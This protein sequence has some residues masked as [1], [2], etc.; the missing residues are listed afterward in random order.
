MSEEVKDIQTESTAANQTSSYRSIFKAT[1]LFGGVQ[2][3][4][5][6]IQ[7]IRSK[8]IAILLG[9]TGIGIQGL[10]TSATLFVR[11]LSSMGLSQSAVKDVS[12][13][14]LSGEK[15]KAEYILS[16]VNKLVFYTGLFG[17]IIVAIFSP[18]LSKT[19]FGS[20]SY[21]ISFILLSVTLLFDQLYD[22]KR[23]I[24]QGTRQLKRLA[25]VSLLSATIA[26]LCT[27]PL[28]YIWGEKGIVPALIVNSV[29][30]YVII[31][32]LS[33]NSGYK[34]SNVKLKDAITTGGAMLKMGIAM[35]FSGIFSTACAYILRSFIRYSDGTDAVGLY[36]AGFVIINTYVGLVFSAITTDYYPRLAAV[37]NDKEKSR[38]VVN[39]QGEIG[40]IILAPLL[41]VCIL[42]MPLIIVVLYSNDFMVA[43]DFIIYATIGMVFR[44]ISVLGA[45]LF[46]VNGS[47]RIYLLNEFASGLYMLFLNI[48]GYKLGGLAGLGISYAVG[49]FL[50]V[51]QVYFFTHKLYDYSYSVT[52]LR[53]II[54]YSILVLFT[55]V[56]VKL[57]PVPYSWVVG[58]IL[59]IVAFTLAYSDLNK[60]ILLKETILKIL[61]KRNG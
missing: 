9:P 24:L 55:I 31:S 52:Y 20:F 41:T 53:L 3:F 49:Y 12:E 7:I 19:S 22:G 25:K 60:R 37:C 30:A 57:L 48:V 44:L 17:L 35:S 45:F 28:Y 58:S 23:V 11:S 5:I 51:C 16:V 26:L 42:L 36:M 10:F 61:S 4:L 47:T 54:K 14:S 39:K 32:L 18:L 59:T 34:I 40:I 13:A 50:F 8:I 2:V 46:I 6:I 29:L 27:V 38:D 1:S 33:K 43:F 21:T 15:E 56:S